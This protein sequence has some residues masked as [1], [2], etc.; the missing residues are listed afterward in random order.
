M[1]LSPL[2]KATLRALLKL[3]HRC[4]PAPIKMMLAMFLAMLAGEYTYRLLSHGH[5][6]A[7]LVALGLFALT[8]RPLLPKPIPAKIRNKSFTTRSPRRK[9]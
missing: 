3:A 8:I 6:V 7:T 5:A 4:I 2:S 9:F 1:R